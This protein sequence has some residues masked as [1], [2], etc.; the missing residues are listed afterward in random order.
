MLSIY[1]V[2]MAPLERLR[3]G[4]RRY[5]ILKEAKGNILE[6]GSGTG[7]NLRYYDMDQIHSLCI[8]D[9]N[10]SKHLTK[11]APD[12]ACLEEASASDLPYQDKQFDTIVH[13]L[14]FCSVNH[15]H[16]GMQELRRVLKDDGQ[17][18]FIEHVLPKNRFLRVIFTFINP[19][20]MLFSRECTL[21]HDF[22]KTARENGFDVIQ[23][24]HFF[25][26]SFISGKLVKKTVT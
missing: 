12:I 1:D 8:T 3:I 14:V 15:K 7:A 13:T 23:K 11:K 4:K 10:L 18:L 20:W 21:T 5:D 22:V 24:D 16:V 17:I 9:V 2:F 6:I 25:M 19:L 26:T